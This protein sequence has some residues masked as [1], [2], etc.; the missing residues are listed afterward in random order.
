[1]GYFTTALVS[2]AA[3]VRTAMGN[4]AKSKTDSFKATL[5]FFA[6]GLNVVVIVFL[7]GCRPA[8]SPSTTPLVSAPLFTDRVPTLTHSEVLGKFRERASAV[9]VR[10]FERLAGAA[11]AD[12]QTQA[13]ELVLFKLTAD[14]LLQIG[15]AQT[16]GHGRYFWSLA[17]QY[18]S[19]PETCRAIEQALE[20]AGVGAGRVMDLGMVGWSVPREQFFAARRALLGA[21]LRT[22][23]V[24]I[25][26]PEFHLK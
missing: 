17:A 13:T 9:E 20:S 16:E 10:D 1:M 12:S 26:E 21:G 25:F 8:A 14:E 18:E 24:R 19:S 3:A 22:N 4:V 23:E 5:N 7:S 15:I 6:I 2:C 11:D